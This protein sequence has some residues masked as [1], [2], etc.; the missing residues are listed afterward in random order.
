MRGLGETAKNGDKIESN[1]INKDDI[2]YYVRELKFGKKKLKI[3]QG[4]IGDVGCVVWDSA[5]VA[6]HYFARLQ[7]FWKKKKVL[8]LGAGTG[9]CSILLAALGADVVA[10]DLPERINLLK[11]NIRE[12]REVIT[13]NEGFIEA[14]IL[15]WNDPCN[16]PLSFDIVVMVD[17]IYY[18]K[19]LDGLVRTMLRLEGSTIICCYEVRDIGEPEVA[20][21][22]FFKM[23]SPYFTVCPVNDE[24]LDPASCTI[25]PLVPTSMKQRL[26]IFHWIGQLIFILDS[27]SL[28]IMSI[29]LDDKVLNYR[30]ES[31]SVLGDKIIIDVGKRKAGD[32]LSL[33]IVYST[34]DQCSAV[35]FLKAEQTVTKKK[36]YLFSQCQ[37]IN[38][39]SLVPCMDTPSVKQTYDAV[40]TVP[41]DLICLMSATAVGEPEETG[42]VKKYSFKQSIRIPS[43]LLAIVV[44]LMV[45]RDLSTRCAV[46]AEPK[47]VDKAF[48][49]FGETEKMLQTA[50]DLVGKYEWG[51]YDLVVLPSSF[52]YGGMENPCLTFATPALLAGDRSAAYVIAHEISHSWTGNLVSNANWEHFWL[53]EGFTT[54]LERKIV[55]KLEGEQ[56]RHFEAQCG[57][58]EHLLSAVK[59]Q[60]SDNHPF[61]KLIPDLQNRDP[62]DAYSLVPYE[63]GSALLMVLEQKLGITPF[64][65]FLRKYIEK[66]AQKSIVTDDWKAFLYE[67]FS[68]KKNILDSI[69]WE[70]WLHDPGMP[71][72][73]PQFDDAAMRETLMLA[74]EWGNM[75]D[76]DL[77]SIDSSKYLSFST[78]QKI[79]VLDHLRLKKGPLSHKKLARLDE[80]MEFSKT[81]N[82]DILSSWIQLALKNYWKA[83]IPVAL[84][85]VTQQGRIKYLRPIYR[86]LFLWSESASRAIETFMKNGP[87][88]H[89]VTVSVVGKLIPK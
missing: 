35:Q 11:R 77:M 10:T 32:K 12:N 6:C 64:N 62:E 40:V 61:T 26:T 79:K 49:E 21:H 74:E 13:G 87:S 50:E 15:D 66:F 72:T 43:Y 59:E 58:E 81:G 69:D 42:E 55:G 17:T 89:P 41:N 38:A 53:N 9:L 23:I 44:G 45:K 30:V 86:D 71:K 5:I 1:T 75:A 63:K 67:Y 24:E 37:A 33:I 65:E 85:F 82:C 60:Y 31:A 70:N 73:K 46:W 39:R 54:F 34:G 88:M 3:N 16:K 84:N 4:Y 29:K 47:V 27:R 28:Q 14:K 52:P 78:Q 19:A 76:C 20:Q 36:P 48:Y 57:W 25:H 22:Q 68:A 2:L 80:L 8:E 51:R 18:L 83:I 7:S 56:Q